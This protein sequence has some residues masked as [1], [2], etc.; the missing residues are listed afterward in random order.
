MPEAVSLGGLMSM[1]LKTYMTNQVRAALEYK[2]NKGIQMGRDPGP[3]AVSEWIEKYADKYR[4]EYDKCFEDMVEATFQA[5]SKRSGEVC[6]SC[7]DERL[8]KMS[9]LV[10][11]EFTR[12]WFMEMAKN[13]H[14]KHVEEI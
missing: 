11:E 8:R 12:L 6:P 1:D 5:V 13:G 10:V 14:S 9:R 7:S 3:A 2:W 4:K